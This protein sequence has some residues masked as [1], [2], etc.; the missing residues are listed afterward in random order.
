[1]AGT[2]PDGETG[3]ARTIVPP[4]PAAPP[5][6]L[7]LDGAGV[8]TAARAGGVIGTTLKATLPNVTTSFSAASPSVT[9]APFRNVLRWTSQGL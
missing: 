1:M 9:L 5:L 3:R 2:L 8:V 4:A 7:W 6:V